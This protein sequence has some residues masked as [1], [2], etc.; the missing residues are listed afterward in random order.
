MAV[1]V[2]STLSF[3]LNVAKAQA[4]LASIGETGFSIPPGFDGAKLT[5]NLPSAV[6]LVY[7]QSNAKP[8]FVGEA[9]VPTGDVSGNVSALDLRELLLRMPGLSQETVAQLRSMDD[10]TNTLPIPLPRDKANWHEVDLNGATALVVGDNTGLGGFVL[11]QQ[12]G[13]VYG[14]GGPFTE[15]ELL[16]V[17]RSLR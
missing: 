7:G 2:A 1:R 13:F 17:A 10:W 14:V 12:D 4:Y 15:Q 9:G 6:L 5:A 3:T 8:L 16:T 11:W